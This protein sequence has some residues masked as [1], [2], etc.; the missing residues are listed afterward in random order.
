M[1]DIYVS[2]KRATCVD[3]IKQIQSTSKMKQLTLMIKTNND[4][5]KNHRKLNIER[6]R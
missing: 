4:K 5:T 6:K 2:E 1:I 3:Q